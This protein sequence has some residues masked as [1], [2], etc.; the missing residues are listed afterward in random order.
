MTQREKAIKLNMEARV[1]A[2]AKLNA[3]EAVDYSG[4]RIVREGMDWCITHA[5]GAFESFPE[6][7]ADRVS[8][9]QIIDRMDL[10]AYL[11]DMAIRYPDE[12]HLTREEV[13]P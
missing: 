10:L 7:G 6:A 9:A 1:N 12:K 4:T 11:D 13:R 8:A 2:I 3:G 5:N